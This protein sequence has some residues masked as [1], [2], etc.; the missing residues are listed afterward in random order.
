MK[1]FNDFTAVIPAGGKGSRF[2]K[3]INKSLFK[4]K[5]KTM[6]EIILDK[7]VLL[8]NK[9]VIVTS[10]KNNIGIKKICKLKKYDKMNFKFVLQTKP[11]GMGFAV[12]LAIPK[13]TTSYFFLIWSDQLCIT[14]KTMANTLEVFLLKKKHAIV[15]PTVKK[16]NPYTLVVKNKIGNVIDILQSREAPISK[17][18]GET[19][20]GFF[21]C[22]TVIIKN[23]LKKLIISKKIITTK[24]KEYDFIKSFKFVAKRY[25]ISTN[26]ANYLY[27]SIGVN[28]KKDL[29]YLLKIKKI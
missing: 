13:I 26:K 8:T 17:N 27:E 19:D 9:I 11:N 20:C 10:R 28:T 16:R 24:T 5:N 6:F 7:V 4:I 29:L 21:V 1:K 2:D 23:F 15:F 3:Q 12:S 18:Y 25:L 22:N 14:Y